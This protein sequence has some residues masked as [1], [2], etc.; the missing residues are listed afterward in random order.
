MI[1]QGDLH[2]IVTADGKAF[3]VPDEDNRF[4]TYVG[5]GAPP[6]EYIT[7]RS[8]KQHGLT[9][10]DALLSARSLTIQLWKKAACSKLEYWQNRAAIHDL[11]RSNRGGSALLTLTLPEGGGKRAIY[12]DA[13]PGA[14]FTGADDNSWAIDEPLEFIAFDPVWFDP[15]TTRSAPA[16]ELSAELVF[17]IEFDDDDIVFGTS[18]LQFDAAIVYIGNWP[19]YPTLTIQGPYTS[20]VIQNLETLAIIT[21]NVP[22]A[23]NESRI[24]TLAPNNLSIVNELGIDKFGDL[25]PLT[26]LIDFSIQ[27]DPTVPGGVQTLQAIFTGGSISSAFIVEYNTRYEAI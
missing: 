21:L 15:D 1:F 5:Y 2:S 11:L 14:Q 23:S 20:V 17:P 6:I 25:G 26:N 18:G 9:R 3:H 24:I 19:A 10:V 7:R 22:I 4:L 12:I 27:P 16:S 13:N 8:Y